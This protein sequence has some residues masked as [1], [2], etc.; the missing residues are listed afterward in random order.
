MGH[1]APIHLH[2]DF[3][4]FFCKILLLTEQEHI[5]CL[6]LVGENSYPIELTYPRVDYLTV[7]IGGVST[8]IIL[9]D[10]GNGLNPEIERT[11]VDI[12]TC[13][14]FFRKNY[15]LISIIFHF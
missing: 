2:L 14:I 3:Y 15:Y 11:G 13:D 1:F 10:L 7:L 4:L 12:V 9:F 6:D 8:F 5:N